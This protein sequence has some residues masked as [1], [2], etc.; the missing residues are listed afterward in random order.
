[1]SRRLVIAAAIVFVALWMTG[2]TAILG[3]PITSNIAPGEEPEPELVE[4][5]SGQYLWPYYSS[6]P[7]HFEQRSAINVVFYGTVD[8]VI[9]ILAEDADWIETDIEEEGD[10]GTEAYS[11]VELEEADPDNPLGW[12]QAAG[13]ER[14][15]YME[16]GGEAHWLEE[17]EQLH[18]GDYYGSRYHL[19]L[20][21][22]PGG[23]ESIVAIQAHYEHFDWFT[24]RHSV[25]S[26]ERA[27]HHVDQDL[28]NRL[29][30]DRVWQEYVGNTEVYDSNGWV[31]FAELMLIPLL[32]FLGSIQMARTRLAAFEQAS[33]L[34][35][36][37]ERVSGDH[38]LLFAVMIAIVLFVRFAGIGLERHTSLRVRWI[39]GILY[40]FMALGLPVAA[41]L[42]AGL[43]E[44]R[45]DAAVA[46]SLG[47]SMGILLDYYYLGT[48]VLPIEII[49]HRTGLVIA[50]GLIAAGGAH[51]AT[52][53]VRGNEFI[54]SGIALW[55]LLLFVTLAGLL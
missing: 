19:R 25:T 15:A 21:E 17:S 42:L 20:Y 40:P 18:D 3:M 36:V 45:I 44:R 12:G 28:I 32:V 29:G 39:A 23:E 34:D 31:T 48:T 5:P 49:L 50:I 41:Y 11:I 33:G 38:L 4:L 37:R 13:T 53:E 52:S 26:V 47:L 22:S 27:Q 10:A 30:T 6:Q 9:S 7:G 1:M 14:F 24:L 55:I 51:R 35:H 8:E 46:A 2:A 16:V 54:V 43:L